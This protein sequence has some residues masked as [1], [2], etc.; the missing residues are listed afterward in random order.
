MET[1]R[2]FS[3]LLLISAMMILATPVGAQEV[4]SD[5]DGVE[6]N[7]DAFP[8][9]A[10]ETTDTDGDGV[11]DNADAFPNDANETS[12][13]DGDGVGDNADEDDDGDGVNDTVDE[14]PLDPSQTTDFDGDGY[15]DNIDA[16]PEDSTEWVD[17]DGDG[18]GDNADDF[19]EDANETTDTDEDGIGDNEDDDADGDGVLNEDDAFPYDDTETTDT[20]GDGVG[21]NADL[22]DDDD[23]WSDIFETECGTLS[24]DSSSTPVDT[25]Y[26]GYCNAID[27]DDDGDGVADSIDLR[28]FT[29]DSFDYGLYISGEKNSLKMKIRYTVP[30]PAVM[31]WVTIA[32][33][34]GDNSNS[35]DTA[36]EKD[37]MEATLCSSPTPLESLEG[38]EGSWSP[39]EWVLNVTVDGSKPLVSD[40]SCIWEDRR[41]LSPDSL[42]DTMELEIEYTLEISGTET[43]IELLIPDFSWDSV[44]WVFLAP[45]EVECRD[46]WECD[47]FTLYPAQ[48]DT[49]LQLFHNSHVAPS[50]AS[51]DS[52][53]STG[54]SDDASSSSNA[55]VQE[56]DEIEEVPGFGVLS[57]ICAFTIV[58]IRGSR[59][60]RATN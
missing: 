1:N 38:F 28:P 52:D 53:T 17:T 44:N 46:E 26:D 56:P 11:G 16:F 12:D 35:V 21:D 5:G 20:D 4:D 22:D 48:G 7:A 55:E 29:P 41:S 37:F 58:A 6:D 45:F 25:D 57:A 34:Y 54:T 3:M 32:D 13:F 18:V 50:N 23:G 40:D 15:G 59:K 14:F 31:Q 42:L 60:D 2:N 49:M 39:I 36:S 19:P 47:S 8:N 33:V 27:V 24:N 43:S 51:S 9:D 30:A 10:N